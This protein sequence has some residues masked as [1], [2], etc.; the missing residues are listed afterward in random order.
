MGLVK[1][2][3]TETMSYQFSAVAEGCVRRGIDERWPELGRRTSSHS[4]L[5]ITIPESHVIIRITKNCVELSRAKTIDPI[6]N[7]VS[8]ERAHHDS[9]EPRDYTYYEELRGVITC[10]DY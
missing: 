5:N 2:C 3:V 4:S 9:R 10:E 8:E 7:Q 6:T 1:I